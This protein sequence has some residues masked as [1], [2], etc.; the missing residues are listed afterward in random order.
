VLECVVVACN[1]VV[2]QEH[3][4]LKCAAR[5]AQRFFSQNCMGVMVRPNSTSCPMP[6]YHPPAWDAD[7]AAGTL[8]GQQSPRGTSAMAM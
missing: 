3:C 5:P 1:P 2:G 7:I 4:Q 8:Q 6:T